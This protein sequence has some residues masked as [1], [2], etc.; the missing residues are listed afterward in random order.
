MQ[1]KIDLDKFLLLPFSLNNIPIVPIEGNV[2]KQSKHQPYHI[3]M[4]INYINR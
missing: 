1:F 4:Q 3:W 2:K